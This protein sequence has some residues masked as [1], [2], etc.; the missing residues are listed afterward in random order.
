MYT[1]QD[2]EHRSS[3]YYNL[4]LINFRFC[5][6]TKFEQIYCLVHLHFKLYVLQSINNVLCIYLEQ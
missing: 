4:E 5:V 3:Y 6:T 2:K 1:L